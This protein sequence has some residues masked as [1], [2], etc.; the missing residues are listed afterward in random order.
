LQKFAILVVVVY[1]EAEPFTFGCAEED[2]FELFLA[3]LTCH[4]KHG[5]GLGSAYEILQVFERGHIGVEVDHFG[6]ED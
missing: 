3:V 6:A 2:E 1:H 4:L 5:I